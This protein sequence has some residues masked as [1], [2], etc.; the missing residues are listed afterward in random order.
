MCVIKLL[1][2]RWKIIIASIILTTIFTYLVLD[3]LGSVLCL[4]QSGGFENCTDYYDYLLDKYSVCHCT[5]VGMH[6][7]A[8]QYFWF[9]IAPFLLFYTIC[10]LISD[11]YLS[12]KK[13]TKK[14]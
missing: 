10:L 11:K 14:K 3:S 9:I 12:K 1:R 2:K 6:E 13:K 8:G 4:C 7:V 5:C